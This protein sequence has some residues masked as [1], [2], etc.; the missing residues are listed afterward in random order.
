MLPALFN[1]DDRATGHARLARKTIEEGGLYADAREATSVFDPA[2][3]GQAVTEAI[4]E[5]SGRPSTRAQ[6]VAEFFEGT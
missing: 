2:V 4:Q 1:L 3:F 5:A 6:Q